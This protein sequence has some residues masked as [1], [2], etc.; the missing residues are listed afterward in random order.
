MRYFNDP[1]KE[2]YESQLLPLQFSKHYSPHAMVTIPQT[3]VLDNTGVDLVEIDGEMMAMQADTAAWAFLSQQ[4]AQMYS[5]LSQLPLLELQ[6]HWPAQAQGSATEFVSQLY[7]RGLITINGHSSIDDTVFRDSSNYDEG[8]LVELLVTERCNLGCV[9][10]LAGTKPDM[11]VMTPEIAQRTIDLAYQMPTAKKLAF[12]F[13]GGE[14]F[15]KFPLLQQLV[16]YITN[17]PQRNQ[18]EVSLVIQT[19]CTLLDE[20]RVQ[21]LKDN[22]IHVG[23]SLDGKPQSHNISRPQVNGEESFS[24]LIKGIDLLQRFEV[25]F[26]ALIVLNRWNIDSVADLADFLLD[27]G[28][29]GFKLNPVAFLGT[30]RES[31]MSVNVEET[32]VIA[33][34][35]SLVEMVAERGYLLLEDNVRTMCEHLTSKQ[36]KTRCLRSH[37][38]A[39]DTFQAIAASGDIYP[40]GRAT[41]TPALKLGNVLDETLADLAAAGKDHSIL[42]QIRDR[43]PDTL[44]ECERCHYKQL[45]QAGCSVQ[46]LEKYDT[47]RHRTPEC[48]FYKTLYPFLMRWLSFDR[49]A[50][51]ALK[52]S[53]YFQPTALLFDIDYTAEATLPAD[54]A[55]PDA[56]AHQPYAYV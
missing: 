32:E 3:A 13:S 7:R 25:P 4:E 6:Q 55:M 5:L 35:K 34:F 46:A 21:W 31:W 8:H 23:I 52:S 44:S 41:Q 36:R 38:G 22:N 49:L 54:Y 37:C 50:F 15:L 43:R 39:G 28:I 11:P 51:E 33:Y 10:C 9:Y 30:A 45:C 16:T 56:I 53:G 24:K 27:N 29:H 20:A 47:V 40:C 2:H 17:H 48:G 1:Y 18:R 12:E 26:G 19:N 42:A 14:P